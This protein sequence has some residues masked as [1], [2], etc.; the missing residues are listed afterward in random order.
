MPEI[1]I[2]TTFPHCLKKFFQVE[3]FW[4]AGIM[5]LDSL[6]VLNPSECQNGESV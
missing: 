2:V 3:D 1:L 6:S 5:S 4:C